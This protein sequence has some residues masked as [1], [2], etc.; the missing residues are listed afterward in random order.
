MKNIQTKNLALTGGHATGEAIRQINPDVMAVYPITPQTPIVEYFAKAVADGK[1]DTEIIP[2]ESEH[3]AMSACIG[4]AAAGATTMTASSSQGIMYMME[5][6][7]VASSM[8]LPIVMAV[9]NRAISGPINI[10]G[11][12]SDAMAM[13]DTGWIQIFSENAQEAYDNTILSTKIAHKALL[14]TTINM[15]GFVTS[16]S[17]ENLELLD[18]LKVKEF[19]G[20][21]EPKKTLFDFDNPK[22]FGPVALQNSYFE[23]RKQIFDAMEEARSIFNDV[24]VDF[25]KISGRRY[26]QV[27]RYK[28]EDATKVIV[29]I[30]STAGT[31]K[32]VVD[33]LREKGGKVGLL[34]IRL[35]RPF[36]S[37]NVKEALGNVE[38]VVVM[39]KNMA[40]GTKQVLASEVQEAI[41]REVQS[42]VYGLGGRDVYEKQIIDLFKGKNKSGY[43][44]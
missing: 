24:T 9:S 4:S 23:F 43:I 26:N 8:R 3:S 31:I 25:G 20:K 2:V 19:I 28:I 32:E 30:G 33:R 12:H 40:F 41:G 27:E 1:S 39:D 17:V 11:D 10:H 15:D 5:V 34:K 22:T 13:R 38:N 42:V 7:P 29:A 37:E 14:P 16:H 44:I 18:D 6:L 35:F 21:Y 36:P